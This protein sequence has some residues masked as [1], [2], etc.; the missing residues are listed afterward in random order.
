VVNYIT[1]NFIFENGK[2]VKHADSFNFYNWS[3][4]AFGITGLLLGWTPFL[5]NKVG[6]TAMKSLDD[7]MSNS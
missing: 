4:Q 5:K 2:I 3:K 6:K 7:Y 1:A